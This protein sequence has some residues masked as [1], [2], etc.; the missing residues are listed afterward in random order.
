MV[1]VQVVC[2]RSAVRS[3]PLTTQDSPVNASV[4]VTLT[5]IGAATFASCVLGTPKAT[6]VNVPTGVPMPLKE[7]VRP[8]AMVRVP[9]AA[10]NDVGEN[11]TE[12]VQHAAGIPQV[13]LTMPKAEPCTLGLSATRAPELVM[14]TADAGLT[15]PTSISPKVSTGL[16][17]LSAGS[18]EASGV[19]G[20]G[21]VS[22][23][24]MGGRTSPPDGLTSGL[25]L[26]PPQPATARM[27]TSPKQV[28][29][30]NRS[31]FLL[32]VM[33]YPPSITR[34]LFRKMRASQQCD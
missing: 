3:G 33:W 12:I 32:H 18:R 8:A 11:A 20:K 1:P 34:M 7:T 5:V 28:A 19:V 27:P 9:L 29:W 30:S 17:T 21:L 26:P 13:V 15:V 25:E 10:P 4:A 14:V 24:S 31:E 23:V 22:R 16:E 6:T 2:A